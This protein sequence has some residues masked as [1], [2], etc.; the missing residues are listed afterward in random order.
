MRARLSRRAIIEERGIE[1]LIKVPLENR[2][3]LWRF[4]DI[5][6]V[7]QG[8]VTFIEVV[9][10]NKSE[11]IVEDPKTGKILGKAAVAGLLS[12][13]IV[14]GPRRRSE[15]GKLAWRRRA[16]HPPRHLDLLERC[17]PDQIGFPTRVSR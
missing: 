14:A 3:F 6:I 9:F 5:D 11:A 15:E 16:S 10:T 17:G 2:A 4:G 1:C 12:S 7:R 13:W 8:N